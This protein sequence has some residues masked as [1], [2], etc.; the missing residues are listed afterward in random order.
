MTAL[1][2]DHEPFRVAVLAERQFYPPNALQY[3]GIP[4][5]AGYSTVAPLRYLEFIKHAYG[6]HHV[7]TYGM[8]FLFHGHLD[9][10]TP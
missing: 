8:L 4:E 9:V 6:D 1:A 10:L 7:T 2:A 5:V 3:Y